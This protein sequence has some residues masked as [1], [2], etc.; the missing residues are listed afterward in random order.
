LN[1][2]LKYVNKE[3]MAY[4]PIKW[5]YDSPPIPPLVGKIG[6]LTHTLYSKQLPGSNQGV[7]RFFSLYWFILHHL[8]V[9]PAR[10]RMM[11]LNRGVPIFTDTQMVQV[12][13]IVRS[14][15]GTSVAQRFLQ[16]RP[17]AVGGAANNSS[18]SMDFAKKVNQSSPQSV[19]SRVDNDPSRSKFWDKAIQKILYDVTKHIPPAFDGLTPII[20]IL[21]GLEQIEILGPL[22]ATFFDTITIGLPTL[23]ELVA[24]TVKTFVSLA[25]I[26][27]AS[28]AGEFVA[29]FI[30]F[31]FIMIS[32]TMS[33]SR[34]Q[35][36]TAFTVGLGAVPLYGE[37]VS[38]AALMFEKGMER[39]VFN[40]H[41]MIDSVGKVSPYM[42]SFIDYW[43][44][45]LD[46]NPG[47][48]IY[49]D[50]DIFLLD[51]FKTAIKNHGEDVAVQMVLDPSSMPA[52]AKNLVSDKYKSAI[53]PGAA[54]S[55]HAS[56]IPSVNSNSFIT[57]KIP[58]NSN[59]SMLSKPL[60]KQKNTISSKIPV[61]NQKA[62]FRKTRKKKTL[63][64]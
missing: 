64:H 14:Q 59:N 32:A 9:P 33:V 21:Y 6:D 41:K 37:Q 25:P 10:L 11:I 40:K 2:I 51:L 26:P 52:A 24:T 31:V 7:M 28:F 54:P 22:L 27:Y 49:F 46:Q 8:D 12:V 48:P 35:F 30:C 17:A 58:L 38:D 4:L 62:G 3:G 45:E 39:Y 63:P 19:A 42:A 61:A 50:S 18:S 36:G 15:L 23:A 29:W 60:N 34:K 43:A 1:V 56:A 13:D 57:N 20:F 5:D 16:I 44:P 53:G 47:P 55:A